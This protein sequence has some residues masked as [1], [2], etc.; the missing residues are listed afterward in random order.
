M[1]IIV[2]AVGTILIL[3]LLVMV[4]WLARPHL[5]RRVDAGITSYDEMDNKNINLFRSLQGDLLVRIEIPETE[6]S[7]Y[8]YYPSR[9]LI[10]V[11][12][13]NQFVY[14]PFYAFS[15]DVPPPVV[16]SNDKI[17]IENG[18]NLTIS[19]NTIE[20]TTLA[21]GI[22]RVELPPSLEMSKIHRL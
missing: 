18:L 12:N 5:W 1:K 13:D 21:N 19:G 8:I 14:F 9:Q 7:T 3:V 20:F 2:I 15:N 6:D 22:V 17:K 16:M 11:P 4:F 10:G